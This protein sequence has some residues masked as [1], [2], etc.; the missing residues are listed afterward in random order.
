MKR[1]QGTGEEER[2]WWQLSGEGGRAV[3]WWGPGGWRKTLLALEGGGATQWRGGQR[4]GPGAMAQGRGRVSNCQLLTRVLTFVW[5]RLYLFTG[6]LNLEIPVYQENRIYRQKI[7]LWEL[8]IEHGTINF[9]FDIFCSVLAIFGSICGI[10][11]L[12]L[13]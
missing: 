7:G 1:A 12:A 5:A 9:S 3:A 8:G 10:F 11:C 2:R 4:G 13:G 6:P